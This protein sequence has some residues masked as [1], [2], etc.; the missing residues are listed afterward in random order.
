MIIGLCGIQQLILLPVLAT[1]QTR[2]ENRGR[3][4]R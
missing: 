1:I 2:Y 4:I 3:L